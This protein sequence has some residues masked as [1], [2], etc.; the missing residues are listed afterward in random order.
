[1]QK[2]SEG[3]CCIDED[4]SDNTLKIFIFLYFF[5][6]QKDIGAHPLKGC[7]HVAEKKKLKLKCFCEAF[8]VIKGWNKNSKKRQ[9]RQKRIE[10]KKVHIE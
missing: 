5:S 4:D 2:K 10:I 1:M 9:K 8:S 6:N 3:P 7:W